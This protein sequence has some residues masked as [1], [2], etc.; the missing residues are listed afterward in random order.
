MSS[1]RKHLAEEIAIAEKTLQEMYEAFNI[2]EKELEALKLRLTKQKQNEVDALE[3]S[4]T[5][6]KQKESEALKLGLTNQKQKE[7]EALKLGL[8]NQKQKELEVLELSDGNRIESSNLVLL[9]LSDREADNF[10]LYVEKM[11]MLDS[12]TLPQK[13]KSEY[14]I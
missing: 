6:Q 9:S 5:N 4:L 8:T 11:L 7:L 14:F 3:L 13:M 10:H 12:Y 1:E 2:K